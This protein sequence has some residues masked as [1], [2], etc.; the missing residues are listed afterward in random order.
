[1]SASDGRP[2]IT[3]L[4]SWFGGK[5]T[6]APTIVEELGPHRAYWE[7]A[8]GSMAV[9]FAK[10]PSNHETVNDLHG[11]LVNM[12]RVI[13][14]DAAFALYDR[15]MRTVMCEPLVTD[16]RA[17]VAADIDAPASGTGGDADRAYWYF[18]L[19]WA[20]RNG[21]AGAARMTFQMAVR[22]TSGG[23]SGSVRF[24]SAV[25]SLPWWHRRLRNVEILRRDLFDVVPRIAD[26]QGT[27]IYM[28]PPYL[29][30]GGRS[31]AQAYLYEFGAGDHRTLAELLARFKAARVVVSYYDDPQLAEL[32]PAPHWTKRLVYRQKNLHVQ[33]RRGVG[34]STAPEV[35]LLNGPSY[36]NKEPEN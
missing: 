13:A 15:L 29:R 28:D 6:L 12:A 19:S 2:K 33:S 34:K 26:Q 7:P 9:L 3:A 14:S 32:Y 16:A 24:R 4:S 11:D 35:L 8:C 21:V 27:V 20:A 5:R 25:D 36:A 31:G 1:M 30:R 22:W 18:V 10:P 17:H 23:G